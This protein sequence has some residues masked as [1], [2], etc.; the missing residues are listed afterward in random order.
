MLKKIKKRWP[1]DECGKIE[2]SVGYY[3]RCGEIALADDG[4]YYKKIPDSNPEKWE[5]FNEQ[6]SPDLPKEKFSDA[7]RNYDVDEYIDV[8]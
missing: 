6:I 5:L 7:N 2:D 8:L 3:T 4:K 1:K